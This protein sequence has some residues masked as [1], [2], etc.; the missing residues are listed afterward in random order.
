MLENGIG[1]TSPLRNAIKKE[2]ITIFECDH[3]V[4]IRIS[5]A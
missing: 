2:K 1:K 4:A 5:S 3:L